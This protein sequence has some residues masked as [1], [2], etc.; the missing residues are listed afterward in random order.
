[1][2][3][4]FSVPWHCHSKRTIGFIIRPVYKKHDTICRT[5]QSV[6]L[7]DLS[8]Y[9]TCRA[10]RPVGQHNLWGIHRRRSYIYLGRFLILYLHILFYASFS[11]M[12]NFLR[13]NSFLKLLCMYV[14]VY[15]YI[16]KRAYFQVVC[17]APWQFH[18]V[19]DAYI[20]FEEPSND[21]VSFS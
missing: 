20:W 6:V 8:Y 21:V 1:M 11:S 2:A 4:D 5:T 13:E 10:T 7:H 16:C 9:T 3:S 14:H 15:T 17:W 19:F 12:C 18:T